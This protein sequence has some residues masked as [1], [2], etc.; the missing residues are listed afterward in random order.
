MSEAILG[1]DVGGTFT[2]FVLLGPGG[3]AVHK[4]LSTP[5]DL[6]Q[7][8]TQGIGELHPLET[9]T[10]VHGSTVATNALLERKGARIA[11]I[12]TEG[13]EDL[14]EIGRQSRPLLYDLLQERPP[15][16]VPRELRFGVPE[17]IDHQG[18]AV[19]PLQ[20]EDVRRVV[21]QLRGRGIEAVSV[22]LLFSFLNAEHEQMVKAGLERLED[23]LFIS[24]SSEVLPEFREY[25]RTSTVTVNA[26][27]GPLVAQYLRSLSQALGKGLRIMQSSGGSITAEL[28][29][30]QPV[31][32][33]LSGPAG[34]V[35][36][37][38][39][40]A[41]AAGF[42]HIIT[43]DMGGTSTDVSLCPGRVQETTSSVMGGCPLSVPM[44]DIH[45]VGAGGGSIAHVDVGGALLVGPESAG[46]DPGPACYGRG[47]QATVSD[48]NLL[49]GR[50]DPGHFL[51][52]RMALDVTNAQQV[53]QRLAE[54]MGTDVVGASQGVVRVVNSSME[55]AIRTISLER[56]FD[57][58]DFTLVAFGGAGP[59][60]ACELAQEMHIPRVLVPAYPGVLSALGVA[61]ADVVKDYSQTV[62]LRGDLLRQERLEAVFCGLEERGRGEMAEEGIDVTKL[63]PQR[64]LDVR[65]VG[66]S[67]ELTVDWPAGGGDFYRVVAQSFHQAHD[68]R[69]G[70]KDE[71]EP[72][73][74]VNA[75]LKM[76]SLT[77][78][79]SLAQED[80][81][82]GEDAAEA[83]LGST[84]V[85]FGGDPQ[86]TSL[87][88][89]D[90]LHYGNVLSG[91]A[92]AFQLDA[93]TVIPPGWV[94]RVD[95]YRNLVLELAE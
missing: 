90:R 95:A 60:H 72:I 61:I 58:R 1:V 22:S 52:G 80:S 28:A 12:T 81:A 53:V 71:G 94:A 78:R 93:T 4:V 66:Q 3:L 48:A 64:T 67:Y 29:A 9:L 21:A 89:R 46:A 15:A 73:E 31:R 30:Q 79:L 13:F 65:Y 68:R 41:S 50:L 86:R 70:Y 14:I 20:E 77:E 57:P 51:G 10:I 25:E 27:V 69:F 54:Q 32:T 36:G 63:Q 11:L 24:L 59:M 87:Y 84:D 74:V 16:L 38:R 45:T 83:L 7:A 88:D 82:D 18:A 37:A 35:V 33:I 55:R 44:I 19:S 34:G 17:R 40:V 26:Y 2:D 6:S 92:L 76:V 42:D 43:F 47:T 91:P 23:S 85:I 8:V 49:L 62:M 75:R 39:Y 5:P 56:G